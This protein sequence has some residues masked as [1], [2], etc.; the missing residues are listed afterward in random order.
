[1]NRRKP[2][3]PAD[4][5][6]TGPDERPG[7]RVVVVF[8]SGPTADELRAI[9]RTVVEERLAACV[10]VLPG[11]TSVYRWRGA[12]EESTEAIG[13]AKTTAARVPL[14]EARVRELHTYEVPEVLAC[15]SVGG[16]SDYMDWI[17]ESVMTRSGDGAA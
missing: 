7:D 9:G 12:V 14:L 16:S 8:L 17:R 11:A 15:G 2:E 10:N 13:I 4:D 6:G 3:L 1:M 5:S